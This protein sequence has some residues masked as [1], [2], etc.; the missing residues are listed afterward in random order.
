MAFAST[1]YVLLAEQSRFEN[2]P[3]ARAFFKNSSVGGP[4]TKR[5]HTIPSVEK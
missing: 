1:F 5:D 4:T 2:F 3:V